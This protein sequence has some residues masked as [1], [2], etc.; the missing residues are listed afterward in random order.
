ML[1]EAQRLG[2]TIEQIPVEFI[3]RQAGESTLA[4]PSVIVKIMREFAQYLFRRKN[5]AKETEE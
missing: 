4:R 1:A 2:Y 5:S 3:P